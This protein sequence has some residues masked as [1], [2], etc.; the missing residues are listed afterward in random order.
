MQK[1]LYKCSNCKKSQLARN[2]RSIEH[3]CANPSLEEA[4]HVCLLIR[5][6]AYIE[7]DGVPHP[8]IVHSTYNT[9]TLSGP[10]NGTEWVQACGNS[11]LTPTTTTMVVATTCP[12]CLNYVDRIR[13]MRKLSS[14]E[15]GE[16][17]KTVH[18]T[19]V[20]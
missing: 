13:Q 16:S 19:S 5:N 6:N 14:Q 12:D 17:P 10:P 18:G 15:K 3:C 8:P 2:L 1:K 11:R 20:S 7:L 9:T 4:I